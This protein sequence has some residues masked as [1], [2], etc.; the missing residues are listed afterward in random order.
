MHAMV[1]RLP[2]AS[3]PNTD[4]GTKYGAVNAVVAAALLRNSRRE[5][6]DGSIALCTLMLFSLKLL[7]ER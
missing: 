1:T 2:G 6:P 4:E 7:D 5:T 3:A